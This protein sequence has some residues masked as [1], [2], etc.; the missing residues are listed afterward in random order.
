MI[1]HCSRRSPAEISGTEGS[2]ICWAV[3]QELE[4]FALSKDSFDVYG[5]LFDFGRIIN[6]TAVAH[7]SRRHALS[8]AVPKSG[9]GK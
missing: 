2:I 7:A 5:V 4:E 6:T 3:S 1:T 8:R 9:H